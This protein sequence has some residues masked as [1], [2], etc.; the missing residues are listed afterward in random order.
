MQVINK[1][2]ADYMLP[3]LRT[4]RHY[5]TKEIY[6]FSKNTK[7]FYMFINVRRYTLSWVR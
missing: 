6:L 7:M 5:I 4:N 2:Y 3:F 1:L